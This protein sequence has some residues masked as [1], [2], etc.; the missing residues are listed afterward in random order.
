M[1]LALIA[2]ILLAAAPARAQTPANELEARALFEAGEAA[3]AE[4]RYEDARRL[5]ER[6]LALH[7]TP[8]AA[9]NAA[10]AAQEDGDLRAAARHLDALLGGAH[11]DL[12]AGRADAVR[13]L[14]DELL[15]GV[16]TVEVRSDP[17]VTLAIDGADVDLDAS[18]RLY[19]RPGTH[20]LTIRVPGRPPR[21][22]ELALRAGERRTLDLMLEAAVE[23]SVEPSPPV[24]EPA[25]AEGG[26]DAVVIALVTVGAV[27]VAGGAAVAIG[28]AVDDAQGLPDE[29]V[30]SAQTLVRF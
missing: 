30:G 27:L 19:L 12:P 17:G 20:A 21:E 9:F 13:A 25:R 2:A 3:V 5:F 6:S 8:A 26:D 16:G 28:F 4:R 14:R 10:V 7:A 18:R 24:D 15:E 11:G 22:R 23:R 1:R 29:F